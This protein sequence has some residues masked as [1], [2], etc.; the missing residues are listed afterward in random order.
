MSNAQFAA[1]A[2]KHL[3][4]ENR[5]HEPIAKAEGDAIIAETLALLAEAEEDFKRCDE[6]ERRMDA[7][8]LRPK[9]ERRDR[10]L[11]HSEDGITSADLRVFRNVGGH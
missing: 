11:R 6:L 9:R 1:W 4:A 3:G 8:I 5:Y 10:M 7:K 2:E